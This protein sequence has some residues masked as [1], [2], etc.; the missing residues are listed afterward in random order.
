MCPQSQ[1]SDDHALTSVSTVTPVLGFNGQHHSARQHSSF[2]K[3][4][5]GERHS[6]RHRHQCNSS[7]S[8]SV[9]PPGKPTSGGPQG[10]SLNRPLS[11]SIGSGVGP[12][13]N[14]SF[15]R[16]SQGHSQSHKRHSTCHTNN[17]ATSGISQHHHRSMISLRARLLCF[18]L[19]S[20]SHNNH[21]LLGSKSLS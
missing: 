14:A 21:L 10:F 7:A 1:Q 2:I 17:Q 15:Q 6:T 4:S 16:M 19:V 9:H 12:E 5:N 18:R 20:P 13:T 11:P 3:H 8:L